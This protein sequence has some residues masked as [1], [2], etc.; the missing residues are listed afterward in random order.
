[1]TVSRLSVGGSNAIELGPMNVG[2]VHITSQVASASSGLIFNNVFTSTYDQ[3]VISVTLKA[4]ASGTLYGRMRL[5]GTDE[6]GSIYYNQ[7]LEV[8]STSVGGERA[9]DSFSRLTNI[10][11]TAAGAQI[12]LNNPALT[13]RTSFVSHS[14]DYSAGTVSSIL[15][16]AVSGVLDNAIAYDGINLYPSTGTITGTISILGVKK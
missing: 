16:R 7:Q 9:T 2:L 12:I 15:Y 1:M 13:E 8:G 14:P 6:T 5:S 3:Y 11:T 10:M 4:S